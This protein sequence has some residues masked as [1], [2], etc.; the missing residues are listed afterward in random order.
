MDL[1]SVPSL[2]KSGVF[3]SNGGRFYLAGTFNNKTN[4]AALDGAV[5]TWYLDSGT[6]Y[7][8][9]LAMTN[10]TALVVA[11]SGNLNGVTVN[12]LLDAMWACD[13]VC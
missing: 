5:S 10:G 2:P 8:G 11:G 6:I 1:L 12:G 3:A 13:K 9:A 4:T 7:G